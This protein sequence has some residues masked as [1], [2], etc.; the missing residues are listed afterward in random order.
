MELM[1]V[2]AKGY[3]VFPTY[4]MVDSER[5]IKRGLVTYSILKEII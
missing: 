4:V 1:T 5:V 2:E 3:A